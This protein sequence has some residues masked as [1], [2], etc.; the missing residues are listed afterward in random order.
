MGMHALRID[1]ALWSAAMAKARSEGK[2]LTDVIVS[3]LG[4]Y[5]GRAEVAGVVVQPHVDIPDGVAVVVPARGP[6]VQVH[7]VATAA[8]Q[9]PAATAPAACKHP[10]V[11]RKGHCRACGGFNLG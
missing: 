5:T 3:L 6:M 7:N 8:E 11:G 1:D 9:P 4:G 2:T 10:G